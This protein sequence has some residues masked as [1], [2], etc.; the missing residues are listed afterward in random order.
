MDLEL[1][2]QQMSPLRSHCSVLHPPLGHGAEKVTRPVRMRLNFAPFGVI[3]EVEN[4]EVIDRFT[5]AFT[6]AD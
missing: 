3:A 5:N 2:S 1:R 4:A 6:A